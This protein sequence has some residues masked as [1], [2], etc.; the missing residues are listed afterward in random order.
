MSISWSKLD[1]KSR[2]GGEFIGP[3][4]VRAAGPEVVAVAA[5][6]VTVLV[7][8]GSW[9]ALPETIP[10]HFNLSG[11]PHG[12]GDRST[13]LVLPGLSIVAFLG[14]SLLVRVPHLYNYPVQIT[15]E[16]RERQYA[17]ARLLVRALRAEI[18]VAF[19]C[20]E[21]GVVVAALGRTPTIPVLPMLASLMLIFL[22]VAAYLYAAARGR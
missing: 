2:G 7:P 12:W 5:L 11:T 15:E 18:L 4:A 17:L 1:A 10:T 16:N 20:L 14:L 19:A 6:A 22:T 13:L 8:L 21:W 3:L 9:D